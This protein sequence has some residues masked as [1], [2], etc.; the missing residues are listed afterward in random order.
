MKPGLSLACASVAALLVAG[1]M[2]PSSGRDMAARVT[3]PA[4]MNQTVT[5][6]LSP[7]VEALLV[8]LMAERRE[9][10][11]DGQ[12][13][14]GVTDKFLP[15]KIAVGMANLILETSADDPRRSAYIEGFRDL[16]AL[17]VADVNT[18]WGIYYS[19][20]ALNRLQQAGLLADAVDP[21]TLAR[22]RT[23]LDWRSFVRESDLT[24]IDLPNNYYGVA[25]SVAQLRNLLG[26]EDARAADALLDK[27]LAHYSTYSDFGFADETDGQGRFD[28]YSVLLIGEIAQRFIDVGREPPEQVKA[29]LRLS[30]DLVLL[31]AGPDGDGFEY[32]RS[33]G[34]YGETAMLEVLTAAAVLGV[35]SPEEM[36]VAYALSSAI[37]ARY[38]DFWVDPD[39]GS[40]NLWDEGRR[41]DAYR[42][43]HR[44][45][46]ENLS[47]ARQHV[48]TNA[49]WNRLGYEDRTPTADLAAWR[50]SRPRST[51]TWFDRGVHDRALLTVIDG[52]RLFGLP[53]VNGGPTQH[54][55]NPYFPIPFSPGLIAGS[56]D[57]S[58]PQLITRVTLA[59]GSV[60]QPLAWLSEVSHSEDGD[61]V[62]L[63]VRQSAMDRM[64]ETAPV[65]DD[66]ISALTRY[67]FAPGEV[68][69]HD[70]YAAR[71]G[72]G[73]VNL[74]FEFAAFQP[75]TSVRRDGA[76]WRIAYSG[77]PL[78]GLTV[79]GLETCATAPLGPE[80]QTP[81]GPFRSVVRCSSRARD[82]S[83]PL[84]LGW[85]LTYADIAGR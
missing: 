35:L 17:T 22:L 65:A 73:P 40:V 33:I 26:W 57:A 74:D 9:M 19:L 36:D 27:T 6:R 10:V 29:W 61:I 37:T 80:Y 43:K 78:E 84:D 56:P 41:T 30:A 28:R 34:A 24:L 46:G 55:N 8:R 44:I 12:P 5:Q 77:G 4:A 45:L 14:F 54:M 52:P 58:F 72:T 63:D 16:A 25:Y 42:G 68:A 2:T 7:Q 49:L 79:S 69:R 75:V 62:R 67:R 15:G 50:R 47:L 81:T 11:I 60:L 64:G 21:V 66:R 85:T 70:T 83:I 31:R 82:T 20:L 13:V 48:Y 71:E 23:Q 51:L 53:I 1:C 3:I 32:G 59:D 38:M 76:G 39:T 18:E